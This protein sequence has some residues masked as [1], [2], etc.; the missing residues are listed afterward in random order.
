MGGITLWT[1][2]QSGQGIPF[3]GT[4][5]GFSGICNMPSW[6]SAN[7]MKNVEFVNSEKYRTPAGQRNCPL[8]TFINFQNH[9][10]KNNQN[11][12]RSEKTN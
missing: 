6:D 5:P 10:T 7:F 9:L 11:I 4:P 8:L 1:N 12:T 2:V 3:S